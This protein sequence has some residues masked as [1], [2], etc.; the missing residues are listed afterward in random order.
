MSY[1]SEE[2]DIIVADSL[3]GLTYKQKRAFLC[4]VNQKHDEHIKYQQI[5]IKSLGGGVYNKLKT[6]FL[7]AEYRSGV[8]GRLDGRGMQCVTLK[9]QL[10][11]AMLA[12]ISAPP[13]VLYC[14]GR[15]E[16]LKDRC[17]GVVGSRRTPRATL[18]ACQ[19]ISG[20]L[21]GS[22]TVVTGVADGADTAAIKGALPEGRLICV[23]PGGLDYVSAQSNAAL[24]GEVEKNALII[25]EWPP[26]VAVQKFMFTVRNRIIAG[27]S[28]GILVAAAPKKSGALITAAYAADY[29]REIFAFPHS[30]GIA[31][32][33][34][35][36]ALI[37]NGAT[38][39]QNVLDIL[40]AFGVEYKAVEQSLTPHER[41]IIN[42]LRANGE[43][44]IQAVA[45][46]AGIKIFQAS[47]ALSS[48][49]L[50]GLA[51]RCGGNR[52]AA[53]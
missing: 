48:L 40:S 35:S 38:L 3:E 1:T 14:K 27:M 46:A 30:L 7:S 44:H 45:D 41:A 17:F 52:Y 5:L 18:A 26:Y 28:S 49:E 24:L 6:L 19:K 15:T 39:C 32:G 37:K 13:L 20:D 47:A 12:D 53:V 22:F 2:E 11:P 4:S 31:A 10:Y 21:S 16:L 29:G 42:F 36:N 9:S 25:S 23:F 51:V 8:I 33:E 50:K 43:S 34:G